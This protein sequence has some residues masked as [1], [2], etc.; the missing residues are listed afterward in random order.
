MLSNFLHEDP[1][2]PWQREAFYLAA[3]RRVVAQ[4]GTAALYLIEMSA[5]GQLVPHVQPDALWYLCVGGT[6]LCTLRS[7]E[8]RMAW[9]DMLDVPAN[10]IHAFTATGDAPFYLLYARS[11]SSDLASQAQW[12][13][14][15]GKLTG[16]LK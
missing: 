14:W 8:Q 3:R 5:G 13:T 16:R 9:G 4:S 11:E 6:G 7:Q 15:V 1:T 12:L 10:T 2:A